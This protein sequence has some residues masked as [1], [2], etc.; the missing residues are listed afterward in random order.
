MS[1]ET[2]T[3]LF[4]LLGVF[5]PVLLDGQA[6][7]FCGDGGGGVNIKVG[8][9]DVTGGGGHGCWNEGLWRLAAE[10]A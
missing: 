9:A 4:V 10:N 3:L 7:E 1:D 6:V 8:E 2:C 5:L